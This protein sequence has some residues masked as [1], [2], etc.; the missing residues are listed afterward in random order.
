MSDPVVVG[1]IPAR[2]ASSRLP[3]KMLAKV[4]GKSLIQCTYENVVRC[5]SLDVLY[6][7]T[8]SEKIFEVVEGFGGKAVMTSPSCSNGTERVA[9][10]VERCE[11]LAKAE[12]V[13]NIQGDE[14]AIA[15]STVERVVEALIGDR[16]AVVSTACVELRDEREARDPSVVKCVMDR[17]G[18]ALYF[19]RAMIPFGKSGSFLPRHSYYKHL[20]IYCYRR[21]FLSFYCT[22]GSTPLQQA[23]D[24]EQLKI[25]EH[26][27]RIRVVEVD[28]DCHGIDTHED[29]KK[30]IQIREQV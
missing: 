30:F 16:E 13:V 20:G 26:G 21:E 24:L 25:L 6:V 23:E 27:Y 8:D 2:L 29:L 3:E 12:I 5:S 4:D 9:E 17:E 19:S 7:A 14:P 18:R 10:A 11:E 22:L 15:L 1:V 28:E